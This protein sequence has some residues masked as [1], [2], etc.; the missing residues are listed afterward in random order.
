MFA[1]AS[2]LRRQARAAVAV[3][4]KHAAARLPRPAL[5]AFSTSPLARFAS[6]AAAQIFAAKYHAPPSANPPS[7]RL[8]MGSIS[9]AVTDEY[10]R[11]SA[12][13]FGELESVQIMRHPDGSSPSWGYL[14]FAEQSAAAECLEIW[15]PI[16]DMAYGPDGA[17]APPKHGRRKRGPTTCV[18]AKHGAEEQFIDKI[19]DERPRGAR[20]TVPV[21]NCEALDRWLE[22]PEE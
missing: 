21:A 12:A 6:S 18:S 5:R 8:F 2:T 16:L 22:R 4:T 7:C 15:G 10:I 3:A 13:A 20:Q 11:D 19:I 17:E 1:L 14:T 9:P